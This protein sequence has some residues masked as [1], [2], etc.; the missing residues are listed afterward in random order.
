MTSDHTNDN[1]TNDDHTGDFAEDFLTAQLAAL[2]TPPTPT[3]NPTDGR[4]KDILTDEILTTQLAAPTTPPTPTHNPANSHSED[5]L[6]DEILAA[7][8][9]ALAVDGPAGLL[10]RIAATWV[11]VPSAAGDLYVA[12]THL[13]VAYVRT[14]RSVHDDDAEFAALFRRRFTRPLLAGTRP[15]AG[16]VPAL[17]AHRAAKPRFDLSRLSP[18]E[19]EVLL[20][21]LTIPRGQVRPYAWVAHQIGRPKAVRAVGSALGRNP[22]PVLIPCHRVI[23]S[24]GTLG[25]YV[26]GPPAK[27][28]LLD[29][30][31]TNVGEVYELARHH[32][33]Y[34]G[35][36]TTGVVCFPTCANARRITEAHRHGFRSV[37]EAD[38]AGYRPCQHC[39]PVGNEVA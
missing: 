37:A 24:D 17:H 7:R 6:T 19:R 3:D 39:R 33:H 35:S 32:I 38:A 2:T 5:I 13:G 11:R 15:P 18:F 27:R 28:D 31:G 20:A 4:T 14:S 29:A 8:L 10:G 25:E 23:R 36:D 26:F 34:V 12:S 16:L 9:A 21:V 22:V 30:E 1:H